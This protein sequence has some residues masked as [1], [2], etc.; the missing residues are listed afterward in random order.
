M[1]NDSGFVDVT[2]LPDLAGRPRVA[3]GRTVLS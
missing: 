3:L 2:V 1:M